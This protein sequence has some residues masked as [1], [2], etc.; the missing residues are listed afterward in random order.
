VSARAA[1]T[2]SQAACPASACA[3]TRAAQGTAPEAPPRCEALIDQQASIEHERR[4]EESN[5][6]A[7]EDCAAAGQSHAN[8]TNADGT[9]FHDRERMPFPLVSGLER[10]TGIEP[11]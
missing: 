1:G 4:T 8:R 2:G 11:A 9:H 7:T 3:G 10:A 5:D 6:E